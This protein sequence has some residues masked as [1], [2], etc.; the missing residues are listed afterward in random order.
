[1]FP[2]PA[3]PPE[4]P[5]SLLHAANSAETMP[6]AQARK[7]L[8]RVSECTEPSIMSERVSLLLVMQRHHQIVKKPESRARIVARERNLMH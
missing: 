2:A 4:G 1:M 8:R 3:P 5:E 7:I 6:P